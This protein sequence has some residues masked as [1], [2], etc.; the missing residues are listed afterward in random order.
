MPDIPQNTGNIGRLCF[1]A[2]CRLVLV[3]PMGFRLTDSQLQRAG[4]DYW[5]KL[6][7]LILDDLEEF[8]EWCIGKRIFFLSSKGSQNYAKIEYK[9][10]DVFCF[11]SEAKGFPEEIFNEGKRDG[12]LIKIPMI[13]EARCLNVSTSA[14][15]VL[16][17]ALRQIEKW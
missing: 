7:L 17:E 15:I 4:M 10:G 2:G 11:G 13:K 8:R 12:N 16:F 3:R 14:G 1:A 6:D 5:D 9:L